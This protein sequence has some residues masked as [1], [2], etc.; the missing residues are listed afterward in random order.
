MID[1]NKL[2]NVFGEALRDA[3]FIKKSGSWYRSGSDAI[4]V[5]NLQQSDHGNYYYLNVDVS[6]KALSTELFPKGN[7]CHIQMRADG[8]VGDDI[9]LL[10]KAL[11][12]DQGNE[13]DLSG[14]IDLLNQEILP[15]VGEFLSLDQLREHYKKSTFAKALLFWQARELLEMSSNG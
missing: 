8:L 10:S 15:L 5:L 2:K 6:L 4:V 13:D 1:K 9:L 3:G 7:H 11:D 14:F 12:L